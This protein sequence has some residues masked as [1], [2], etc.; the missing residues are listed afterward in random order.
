M[1][2]IGRHGVREQD[3][4]GM[5]EA[6]HV[7]AVTGLQTAEAV[8]WLALACVIECRPSSRN[9]RSRDHL[10]GQRFRSFADRRRRDKS[11]Q[12]IGIADML[13]EQPD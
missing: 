2:C 7:E 1:R 9:C 10:A 4:H 8:D 11:Q 13:A 12:I 3:I 5:I 6:D